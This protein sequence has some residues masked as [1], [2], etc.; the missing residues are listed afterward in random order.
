MIGSTRHRSSSFASHQA[1][2]AQSWTPLPYAPTADVWFTMNIIKWDTI[3]FGLSGPGRCH[4]TGETCHIFMHPCFFHPALRELQFPRMK[5]VYYGSLSTGSKLCAE[6]ECIPLCLMVNE[7][8]PHE[9]SI[10]AEKK[11]PHPKNF[12]SLSPLGRSSDWW[13]SPRSA[14]WLKWPQIYV[15]VFLL[16]RWR[17]SWG[18]DLIESLPSSVNTLKKTGSKKKTKIQ[19]P[20][21]KNLNDDDDDCRNQLKTFE[22]KGTDSEC[23]NLSSQAR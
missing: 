9:R 19:G 5:H 18:E 15:S 13:M 6:I 22:E 2:H 8:D 14:D 7:D 4:R 10:L 21:A 3:K 17:G 16:G 20:T 1:S 23:Q 12:K 11:N